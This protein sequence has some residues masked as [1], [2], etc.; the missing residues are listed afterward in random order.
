MKAIAKQLDGFAAKSNLET[1][2]DHESFNIVNFFEDATSQ[3]I[4][5]NMNKKEVFMNFEINQFIET[6]A[7]SP[8]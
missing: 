5:S 7:N 2:T 8:V 3:I 1:D 6:N 4:Q